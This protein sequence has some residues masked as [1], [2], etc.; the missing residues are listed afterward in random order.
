MRVAAILAGGENL[1]AVLDGT[2]A[3]A[4]FLTF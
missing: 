1:E 2:I 3:L 4:L